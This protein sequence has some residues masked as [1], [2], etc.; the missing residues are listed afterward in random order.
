[1]VSPM[2]RL[3]GSRIITEWYWDVYYHD[4]FSFALHRLATSFQWRS[5]L[6]SSWPSLYDYAA[7]AAAAKSLQSCLTLHGPIPQP[8]RLPCPW[9]SPGNNTGV[10]CHFL[11]QCMKV[12]SESEVAQ[13]CPTQRPHGL[14]PTRLLRPWDFPGKSTG[15]GCHCLLRQQWCKYLQ[16]SEPAHL[17]S[18]LEPHVLNQNPGSSLTS[19]MAWAKHLTSLA[20]LFLNL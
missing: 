10:G 13:L 12:K 2:R 14:Q 3:E 17:R 8:T 18:V 19:F 20:P 15:V 9:D 16:K 1:M 11:L 5:G 7:A 4:I 6:L